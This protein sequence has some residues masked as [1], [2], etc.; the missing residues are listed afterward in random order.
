MER[1]IKPGPAAARPRETRGPIDL[2]CGT[3]GPGMQAT[4]ASAGPGRILGPVP[5]ATGQTGQFIRAARPV[6]ILH[7]GIGSAIVCRYPQDSTTG[8][9]NI[10]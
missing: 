6:D 5:S 3:A 9:G 8:V 2:K 10:V 7:T 4:P 1:S